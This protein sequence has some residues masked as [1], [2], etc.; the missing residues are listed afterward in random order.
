[1]QEHC[2]G[3]AARSGGSAPQLGH[4]SS[5]VPETRFL[6][7]MNCEEADREEAEPGFLGTGFKGAQ[8]QTMCARSG[9]V[10][11]RGGTLALSSSD[12]QFGGR[13]C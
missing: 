4:G 13:G 1:M 3:T 8:G 9:P 7:Y 12:A 5:T 2:H 11:H 6:S 10:Q